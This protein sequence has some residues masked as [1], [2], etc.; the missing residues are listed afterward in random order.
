MSEFETLVSLGVPVSRIPDAVLDQFAKF[1]A[2][3]DRIQ[4]AAKKTEPEPTEAQKE[5]GRYRKGRVSWK[6]LTLAI[7][8][9]AGNKRRPEWPALE[10]HY[11]YVEGT[12]SGAD[13]DAVDVF[14]SET[15]PDSE[16][17][18]VVNQKK[19][20]G[21]FDEHKCIL[22]CVS[23]DEA[24]KTYLRNYS[25]GWTGMGE[26]AALTL[27]QFKWWL[28][29]ADTSKEVKNGYFAA[30]ENRKPMKKA[31]A[32]PAVGPAELPYRDRAELYA[33]KDGKLF[34]SLFPHGGFGVYGGGIDPGEDGATAAAREFAEESGYS[35]SNVRPLPFE[36]HTFD[37]TPPFS[38]PK[39]A[40][41][42][43]QFK[44]SRTHYFAGDLGDQIPDAKIDELGR[45]DARL[46]DIDEALGLADLPAA[47]KEG[48]AIAEANKKRAAIL[49]HLKSQ[50]RP[51]TVTSLVPRAALDS[52]R[53]HGLLGGK[54]VIEKPDALAAAAAGRGVTPEAFKA[55]VLKT[56]ASWKKY[57]AEGPNVFFQPPPATTQLAANHPSKVHDLVPVRLRLDDLMRD[58]PD[59]KMYGM[60][61]EPYDAKKHV[62]GAER[63][64]YLA[65]DEVDGLVGKTP[66]ELW[67]HYADPEGKGY[68]APDVPHASVH[69]PDGAVPA[70]YLD[71]DEPAKTA[72]V[73]PFSGMDDDER[74]TFERADDEAELERVMAKKEYL[75]RYRCPNCGGENLLNGNAAGG[76]RFRGSGV[77]ADCGESCT[78]VGLGLKSIGRGPEL[79]WSEERKKRFLDSRRLDRRLAKRAFEEYVPVLTFVKRADDEDHPFT[80]AVDFD[81]TLAEA[82]V[83]FDPKTCGEPREKALHWVRLF[84]ENGA[85][86]IIFTVRGNMKPVEAWLKKHDVPYDFINEN[87]D[88]PPGSSGKVYAD[89]YW[90]DRAYNA[91]DPDE[92]GPEIL[93]KLLGHAEGEPEGDDSSP[94]IV[95]RRETVVTITGP[96]LLAAMEGTDDDE[97][98]GED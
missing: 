18:F 31:A 2:T 87:P 89:A 56:L 35:V 13:G 29:N 86:I 55:D 6:G 30:V 10:D 68:Y 45:K 34:G 22:G 59:T 39:Q 41:R 90:D 25:P 47:A 46:Y 95:I 88:Q 17:V 1:A 49:A 94:V 36:P 7:E 77:C 66:E 70:K 50:A 93:N 20:D 21:S 9:A 15:N 57:Q 61:L 75:N 91:V 24:K 37:W 54:A 64:R 43:K 5:S 83:P 80:I 27:S 16:I 52:V 14:V 42:A 3:V 23:T 98:T 33:M 97:G 51:R 73:D 38:S 79:E 71:F 53:K 12:E 92:H 19:P 58:V 48:P 84:H 72:A 40:E 8:T 32:D 81:G 67:K 78:I 85:R 11:G 62:T 74:E 76:V 4:A 26:V 44:G 60:E 82:Q 28:E 63:H 96:S 69:T 65:A